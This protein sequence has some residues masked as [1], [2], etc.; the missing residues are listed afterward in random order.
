MK[1]IIIKLQYLGMVR[2][3]VDIRFLRIVEDDVVDL[4]CIMRLMDEVWTWLPFYHKYLIVS[5]NLLLNLTVYFHK[6]FKVE[7]FDHQHS[8]QHHN[9]IQQFAI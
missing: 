3:A 9:Q 2:N 4:R 8:N 5:F 1:K 7:V 6:L